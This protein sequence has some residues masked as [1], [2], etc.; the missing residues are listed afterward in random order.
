MFL[1]GAGVIS[2]RAS[3]RKLLTATKKPT[4]SVL[5]QVKVSRRAAVLV[6]KHAKRSLRTQASYLRAVIYRDL[7][8]FD[9]A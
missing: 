7:G 3:K 8:I 2:R 4:T 5:L 9:D 1:Y 6:R